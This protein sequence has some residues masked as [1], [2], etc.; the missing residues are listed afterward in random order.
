MIMAANQIL[1]LFLLLLCNG[2]CTTALHNEP[3]N[4]S[5]E[6]RQIHNTPEPTHSTPPH[7]A[8]DPLSIWIKEASSS[9]SS[10][11]SSLSS[12]PN[13]LF[14]VVDDLLPRLGCYGDQMLVTPNID[15]LASKSVVFERAY[16]QQALCGP[17]RTS[18]LTGR[19]PE[20]TRVFDLT[21]YWRDVAGNFT[22][23]PQFFKQ[24]GYFA[25]GI[26]KIFHPGNSGGNNDGD[27]SWSAPNYNGKQPVSYEKRHESTI[28]PVKET[29]VGKLQDTTIADFAVEWLNN[30]SQTSQHDRPFFL[31]VGF[32]K[33]HLPFLYPEEF[34]ALYP[35]QNIHP[36]KHTDKPPNTEDVVF[37][38]NFEFHMFKDIQNFNQ[39]DTMDPLPLSYQLQ[40]RQAYSAAISFTDGLVG[41]VLEA[42]ERNGFTNNT[43][44]SFHGDH[45]YHLGD[46]AMWGK[47]TN[48]E[49]TTRIPMMFHIPG[50][51]SPDSDFRYIDVLAGNLTHTAQ[52]PTPVQPRLRT[53]ALVEAVDLYPTLAELAGLQAPDTCPD[54]NLHVGTCVEGTSLVPVLRDVTSPSQSRGFS[55]KEAAFSQYIRKHNLYNFT[56]MGYSVRTARHRYAEWVEYD[57]DHFQANFSNV[58]ARELYVHATDPDEYYNV[59]AKD[60][61]RLTVESLSQLLR[62]GWRS[63]LQ[64]YLL[65]LN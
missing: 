26:G 15:H 49:A 14:L 3:D 48:Y 47:H 5:R 39:T 44:I 53:D 57:H 46:N 54:D 31:A 13:V 43:I 50:V 55:G 63:T 2:C 41:R 51:T 65:D 64:H 16:A 27:F 12:R 30:R 60:E 6:E 7:T 8:K 61:H 36:A 23:L 18:F 40:L 21:T 38:G 32:H 56:V 35:L 22:T 34:K 29:V 59:E 42:L 52:R 1:F 62:A 25:Q 19:R 4:G 10:P 28:Q 17:S 9:S 24:H 33:P 11:S 58:V 20:S 37:S 45:G